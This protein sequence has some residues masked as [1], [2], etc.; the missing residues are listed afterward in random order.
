MNSP[1]GPCSAGSASVLLNDDRIIT[2]LMNAGQHVPPLRTARNY[3]CDGCYETMFAGETEFSFGFVPAN[4]PLSLP[5][6]AAPA[7]ARPA[8]EPAR[9]QKFLAQQA[10]RRD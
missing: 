7:W 2:G 6:T 5:S 10:R 9:R 4:A 8:H 1:P 3:A